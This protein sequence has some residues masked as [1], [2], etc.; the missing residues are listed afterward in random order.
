MA[1]A[2]DLHIAFR[3]LGRNPKRTALA[4]GSIL[5]A[6]AT[7]IF[8]SSFINGYQKVGFDAVTGPM[9]GHAQVHARGYRKDRDI[10]K[11]ITALGA[12][13]DAI[14]RTKGVSMAT[15]RIYAPVL[16][17]LGDTGH[18]AEIVGVDLAEET[19]EHGLLEALPKNEWPRDHE[20]LL[21]ADLAAEMDVKAGDTLAVVGQGADGAPV[22]GLFKVLRT[23]RTRVDA[24]N[25]RGIFMPLSE[26]QE[27]LG[28]EDQAHEILIRAEDIALLPGVLERLRGLPELQ[29]LEVMAWDALQ[30]QLAGLLGMMDKINLFVLLLVF[31]TAAAGIANTMLM[32]TFERSRE[33]GMLAALGC[34]PRRL[35]RILLY[36]S[37][38]LGLAG[39]GAGL[40]AGCALVWLTSI[41][42]ISLGGTESFSLEG[43][44]LTV[45]YP[46][47]AVRDVI[48][49]IVVVSLTSALACFLPAHRVTRLDPV[50]AMRA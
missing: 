44:T 28:M 14:R 1:F 12:A 45:I 46:T 30:P 38:C 32:A 25:R 5:I 26:A 35:V 21:G 23:A 7:V 49:G 15:A 39:V 41:H 3:N 22:S 47:L 50:E 34:R 24:L 31:L 42:G 40:L 4:M 17:A 9:L 16:T 43:F 6:Q 18:T 19:K 36:E 48:Q 10:Q 8:M 20:V 2:T 33:F 11:T 37:L 29:G 27:F 13:L